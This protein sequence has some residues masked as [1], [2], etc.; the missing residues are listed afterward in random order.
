MPCTACSELQFRELPREQGE[1]PSLNRAIQTWLSTVKM[2]GDNAEIE[3]F[4]ETLEYEWLYNFNLCLDPQQL[5]H[6]ST[7]WLI[8]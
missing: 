1:E 4:N 7:Q 3:I 6:Q 8:E 2:R 5:T